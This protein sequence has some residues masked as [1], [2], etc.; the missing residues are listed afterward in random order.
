VGQRGLAPPR[1]VVARAEHDQIVPLPTCRSASAGMPSHAS[2]SAL[3]TPSDVVHER[4]RASQARASSSAGSGREGERRHPA[5]FA[6]MAGSTSGSMHQRPVRAPCTHRRQPRREFGRVAPGIVA[7][8]MDED[9]AH[10]GLCRPRAR[11]R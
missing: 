10:A 6:A 9:V 2:Q 11:A 5:E 4:K 3:A 8:G 7:G 1:R